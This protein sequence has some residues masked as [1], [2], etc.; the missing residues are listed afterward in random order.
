MRNPRRCTVTAAAG[1]LGVLSLAV[2]HAVAFVLAG[3]ARP[4]GSGVSGRELLVLAVDPDLRHW[5]ETPEVSRLAAAPGLPVFDGT[6][7]GVAVD[8]RLGGSW[9][10]EAARVLHPRARVVVLHAPEGVDEVLRERGL[11]VLAAEG[12]TVVAARG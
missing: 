6:L 9:L 12:E 2:L 8:A 5:P 7:R 4:P 10:R 3:G 11:S 1:V